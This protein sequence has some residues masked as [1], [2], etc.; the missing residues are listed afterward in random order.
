MSKRERTGVKGMSNARPKKRATIAS[1]SA[2]RYVA[3]RSAAP[4]GGFVAERRAPRIEVKVVDYPDNATAAQ[5]RRF[6]TTATFDCLNALKAGS[7]FF[8]RIGRMISMKSIHIRGQIFKSDNHA[9]FNDYLRLMLVYDSQVNGATPA[10][11]T[12][13]QD[14]DVDGDVRTNSFSGLNMEEV[15]RFRILRDHRVPIGL[16]AAGVAN[17]GVY[18]SL[19]TGDLNINWFVKLKG[20][21]SHYQ[22]NAGTVA[23]IVTGALWLVTFGRGDPDTESN[24]KVKFCSRLKFSDSA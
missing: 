19:E 12:L 2:R 20:L 3:P 5:E 17:G 10:I 21:V 13:L 22:A 15:S 11:A 9:I 4:R 18:Q 23:D 14:R 8:N 1:G 24:W 6:S 7:G 16:D